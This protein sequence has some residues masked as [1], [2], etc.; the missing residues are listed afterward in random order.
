M[1]FRNFEPTPQNASHCWYCW[2]HVSST[3]VLMVLFTRSQPG[4]SRIM[5]TSCPRLSLSLELLVRWLDAILHILR[6]TVTLTLP[7]IHCASLY[8]CLHFMLN[9]NLRQRPKCKSFSA[10]ISVYS[11]MALNHATSWL[12][13]GVHIIRTLCICSTTEQVSYLKIQN[14][15]NI[16][17]TKQDKELLWVL[18]QPH[19]VIPVYAWHHTWNY[20]TKHYG[21]PFRPIVIGTYI[22]R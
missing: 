15:E 21:S 14:R 6:F 7:T 12:C 16:R 11:I 5:F 9:S 19:T 13:I 1:H 10:S 3:Q 17:Q 4:C 18:N 20:H 22:R 8:H 2:C